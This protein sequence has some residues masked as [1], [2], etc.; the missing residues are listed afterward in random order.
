[1]KNKILKQL[2]EHPH[3][4]V[5]GVELSRI[6]GISRVGVWKHLQQLKD[7]GYSIESTPKGYRLADPENLLN[8]F[9]FPGREDHIHFYSQVTSTMDE[10]REL[11]RSGAPHLSVVVADNQTRGRGRLNRN[12]FSSPGGLWMSL[13]LR[14]DLPPPLAFKVNFAASFS[15][16]TTLNGLYGTDIRV[17]WPNDLLAGE[18]KVA[19]LLSE[20]ETQG[21]MISFVNIGMGLNVNNDPPPQ[22]KKAVSIKMLLGKTVSRRDI[23]MAFLDK[24]EMQM[25]DIATKDVIGPWKT[26]TATIGKTVTIETRGETGHGVAL[27]VDD[28]GAL[29]LGQGD[30]TEKKVIY[31]DCFHQAQL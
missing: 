25:Q 7:A 11:A 31:G 8:P 26:I 28:T 3:R 22:E 17:K 10:A 16:A 12:W 14:P 27:D 21:D 20:M 19:G 15:M 1:M 5:S 2:W 29:I 18:K 9:C 13:I 6:L 24:F 23:L 30:G 4:I